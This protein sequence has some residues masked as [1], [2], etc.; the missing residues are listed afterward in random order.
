MISGKS[1]VCGVMAYPV[2]HSLSP[3]MHNFFSEKTGI[4]L[5][6]VPLKVETDKVGDAVRGAYALNFTGINVTI[7]HKQEVMK[8]LL[9]I[10]EDAKAIGAVNTLVRLEGGYKGYNTDVPGLLRVMTE[11]GIAI[12]G[13]SCILL[14]A[15][16]AAKAAAYVLAKEGARRIYVLNRNTE[17]AVVL[18]RLINERFGREVMIPMAL[19]AYGKL[20][21]KERYLAVQTTSVGMYPKTDRA[22]I[23]DEAFYKMIEQAVDIV[24]TP[25]V[26]RFMEHV[27]AA[28]GKAVG[29]LD[30]LIYQGMIAYELWN[31]EAVFTGEIIEETRRLMVAELEAGR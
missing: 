27:R 31:P 22:P 2:E 20:P 10:D 26:T 30:M 12:K 8:Y 23:E 1:K 29:G 28:G 19:E 15:G 6:Y 18:S 5:A 11:A 3:L 4:D 21:D 25:M 13:R 14:G 17:R 16:G 24:Y 9:E 7:P